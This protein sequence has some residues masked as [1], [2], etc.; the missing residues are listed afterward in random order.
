M[1]TIDDETDASS[2]EEEAQEDVAWEKHP[3]REVLKQGFISGEIPLS[4]NK[5]VGPGPRA[6]HEMY[7]DLDAFKGMPYSSAFAR[8]LRG[9]RD[10]MRA[11]VTRKDQ[12]QEAF[13]IF[14]QN[15]PKQTHNLLGE[16]RW[17]GSD[18][19]LSLKQD[20][21]A[22]RHVGVSPSVLHLSR[23]E[24]QVFTLKKFRGHINQEVRLRKLH[25]YLADM[26]AGF[27]DEIFEEDEEPQDSD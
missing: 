11:K 1:S 18:A 24:Y 3:A 25:N 4:Y 16:P 22:N 19:E 12:D 20:V 14:R 7:K 8:R 2:V 10:I 26:A 9:L 6:I 15:H 21:E 5:P 13:D 23:P 27:P 17:E